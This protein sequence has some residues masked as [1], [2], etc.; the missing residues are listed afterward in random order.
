MAKR[1]ALFRARK[2]MKYRDSKLDKEL[3]QWFFNDYSKRLLRRIKITEGSIRGLNHLDVSFDY[4]ITA[5]AGVNGSGKS[6]ILALACCAYHNTKK[7]S[8]Y[9]SGKIAITLIRTSFYSIL[10]KSLLKVLK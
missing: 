5:F 8:N 9:Q 4:P 6:T 1:H 3:R 2:S 10:M 7:A